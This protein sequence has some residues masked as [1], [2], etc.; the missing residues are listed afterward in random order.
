MTIRKQKVILELSCTARRLAFAGSTVLLIFGSR[1]DK[2]L[3][4]FG[5][6]YSTTNYPS[7]GWLASLHS[8]PQYSVSTITSDGAV[9]GTQQAA[10]ATIHTQVLDWQASIHTQ[11]FAS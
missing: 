2:R 7:K 4:P 3:R 6:M 1:T 5:F 10:V 9:M 8:K 11:P